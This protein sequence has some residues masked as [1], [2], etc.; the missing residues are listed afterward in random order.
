MTKNYL[1]KKPATLDMHQRRM[2]A[3]RNTLEIKPFKPELEA[4][5]GEF[6]LTHDGSEENVLRMSPKNKIK[7]T[8]SPPKSLRNSAEKFNKVSS[9]VKIDSKNK[10]NNLKGKQNKDILYIFQ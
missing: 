6:S 9:P 7:K 2:K 4:D 5:F 1:N 8:Y 10:V 3:I